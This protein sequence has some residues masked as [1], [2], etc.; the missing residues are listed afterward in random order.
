MGMLIQNYTYLSK[1]KNAGMYDSHEMS[2]YSNKVSVQLRH[3]V[4]ISI[5]AVRSF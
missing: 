5:S 1:N 2:K 4:I 3:Y